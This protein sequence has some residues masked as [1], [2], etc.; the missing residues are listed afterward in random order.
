MRWPSWLPRKTYRKVGA[1]PRPLPSPATD[2]VGFTSLSSK[3]PTAEVFLM[4]SNM[5]TAFDKLTDRFSVYKVRAV[6][7]GRTL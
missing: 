6:G 2:I 5:F 3:L 4:L 7:L 1:A